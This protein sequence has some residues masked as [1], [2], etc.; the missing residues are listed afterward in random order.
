[1][2]KLIKWIHLYILQKRTFP[3]HELQHITIQKHLRTISSIKP[4]ILFPE[5]HPVVDIKWVC[6]E[7]GDLYP[8]GSYSL[9]Q[10]WNAHIVSTWMPKYF[11]YWNVSL[12]FYDHKKIIIN[13]SSGYL[14]KWCI[15][16]RFIY[17]LS[18]FLTLLWVKNRNNQIEIITNIKV[19][20][21]LFY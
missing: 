12:V 20:Q 13:Y 9:G 10:R 15:C 7:P 6:K 8:L 1:M 2:P 14:L 11:A 19:V 16:I 18:P 17:T 21:S 3:A 5:A 4:R